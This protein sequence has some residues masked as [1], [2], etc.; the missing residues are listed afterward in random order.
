MHNE[1]LQISIQCL[2]KK[3]RELLKNYKEQQEL[4]QQLKREN[5]QLRQQAIKGAQHNSDFLNVVTAN[6]EK[7]QACELENSIDDYIKA[8]DKSITYV[9]Q[10][11]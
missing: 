8:V 11:Q 3:I 2:E 1:R 7:M 10:L 4:L 6:G 9:E 5:T